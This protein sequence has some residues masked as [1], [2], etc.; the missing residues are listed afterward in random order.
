MSGMNANAL[1]FTIKIHTDYIISGIIRRVFQQSIRAVCWEW[2]EHAGGRTIIM[3]DGLIGYRSSEVVSRHLEGTTFAPVAGFADANCLNV[4]CDGQRRG[5]TATATTT[6]RSTSTGSTSSGWWGTAT[7]TATAESGCGGGT[8]RHVGTAGFR[9][10]C[11]HKAE[12][13][14]CKETYGSLCREL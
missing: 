10:G 3:G 4:V 11:Q 6:T 9:G 7:T 1:R 8:R 12:V 5:C 2:V 13:C 14:S